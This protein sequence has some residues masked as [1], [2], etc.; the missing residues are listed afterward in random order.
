M[1]IMSNLRVS[2][3]TRKLRWL[4]CAGQS[5]LGSSQANKCVYVCKYVD[6]N[7]S[8]AMLADR[9]SA[10]VCTRGESEESVAHH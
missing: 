4:H 10:G 1:L 9:R 8:A 3:K 2:K 6:G 5:K 7:V